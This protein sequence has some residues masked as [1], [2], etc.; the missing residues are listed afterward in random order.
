MK[1]QHKIADWK[2]AVEAVS[3][4][5][6]EG[7]KVIFTNGCFDILHY[8]HVRYL[9]EAKALGDRLVIGINADA[10][11]R[12]LKG[13]DRPINPLHARQYVLAAL[14]GVD[15][16]VAFE[17]ETPYALIKSLSPD[18]LVKGGDYEADEIVGADLVAAQGGE[19]HVLEYHA[20]YSTSN[21]ASKIHS[22]N[23]PK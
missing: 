4:W 13:Q 16:V 6:Q 17:E 23:S 2:Q 11:V 19:V 12:I 5:Q 14:S 22:S 18:V 1:A 9:E 8:G 20:G 15:L 21:I 3:H 7:L 10:S